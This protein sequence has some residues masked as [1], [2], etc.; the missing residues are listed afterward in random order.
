ML[1]VTASVIAI[2]IVMLTVIYIGIVIVRAMLAFIVVCVCLD[3]DGGRD[4]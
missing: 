4:S 3:S 2:C 1:L